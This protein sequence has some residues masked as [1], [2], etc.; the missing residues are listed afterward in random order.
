MQGVA[1]LAGSRRVLSTQFTTSPLRAALA[2]NA[3]LASTDSVVWV[4]N[5]NP[6]VSLRLSGRT[7]GDEAESDDDDDQVENS[8]EDDEGIEVQPWASTSKR[9]ATMGRSVVC[10]IERNGLRYIAPISREVDPIIPLHF[11]HQLHEVL[12]NYIGGAVTEASLKDHFDIVLALLEEMLTAERPQ[13]TEAAQLRELVVPPSQLLAKVASTA[14]NVAGLTVATQSSA[15]ALLA[16]PLPWRRTGIKYSSNEIYFDVTEALDFVLDK[17][18]KIVSGGITGNVACRSRLSGMPDL[19]LSFTDPSH[20]EDAAFHPSV[21]Y[22]RWTKDKVV[23]FVPPDGVISLMTFRVGSPVPKSSLT[24]S[25]ASS[26]AILPIQITSS[27]TH[28]SQGG[29]FTISLTSRAAANR[30]LTRLVV[31][32]PL[33]KGA[34]GLTANVT[35]GPF[36]RD[37]NG[38]IEGGGA[39]RWDVVNLPNGEGSVLVWT[40]DELAATDRA[41]VLQGQYMSP[42]ESRGASAFTVEFTSAEAGF[43][44]L[45]IAGLKV[46]GETYSVYKGVKVGGR[47]KIEVRCV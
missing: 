47:G 42:S 1:I 28:G 46:T 19:V 36:H 4:P 39:G 13:L 45:R 29:A 38:N 9:Q 25:A 22:G 14:A 12:E 20:I 37:S 21:R 32:V 43:S 40:V 33:G 41:A 6:G 24:S 23:S 17:S 34:N 16:S 5:L 44:G 18:G 35:G 11:L 30:P 8:A 31:R 27:V 15:N 2:I 3:A 7:R 10:Q 26:L